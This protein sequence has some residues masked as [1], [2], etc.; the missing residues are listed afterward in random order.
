MNE[1]EREREHEEETFL[2]RTDEYAA[3]RRHYLDSTQTRR[4]Q[5]DD[6]LRTV[7]EVLEQN[8]NQ[9]DG[10]INNLPVEELCEEEEPGMMESLRWKL[11]LLAYARQLEARKRAQQLRAEE[12]WLVSDEV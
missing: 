8:Y 6:H 12:R 3:C 10:V 11:E 4:I 7:E 5:R 2:A 9:I 1:E